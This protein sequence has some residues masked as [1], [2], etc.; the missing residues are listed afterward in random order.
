MIVAVDEKHGIGKDNKLLFTFEEDLKRFK[1]ITSG[2]NIVMGRNTFLSLP[3]GAL[4]NRKN[5][6]VSDQLDE[7]FVGATTVDSL[8][9]AI[10]AC[11]MDKDV[12]II[13]GASI[14][15]QMFPYTDELYMTLIDKTFEADTFFPLLDLFEWEIDWNEPF[16][17]TT[18]EEA[19]SINFV[20]YIRKP[21]Y[22]VKQVI[23]IRK[24]LGMSRGKIGAQVAHASIA[25][26]LRYGEW[27]S[28]D[29]LVLTLPKPT[30]KWLADKF[31][32]VCLEVNSQDELLEL[33]SQAENNGLPVSLIKDAGDTELGKPTYTTAAI[34]PWTEREIN[35]VTGHLKLFK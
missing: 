16:M 23:M 25:A 2:H 13:G 17:V 34:G 29:T 12:F 24:D 14:Y 33:Y 30:V 26:I 1:Q 32:K 8:Q 31:T 4:P 11:D 18:T 15:R 19:I 3:K 10:D 22:K 27:K 5:I 9:A 6:V 35:A 28:H 7:S 20:H 21:G